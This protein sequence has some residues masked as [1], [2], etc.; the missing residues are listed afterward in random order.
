M[1]MGFLFNFSMMYFLFSSLGSHL[2]HMD[3]PR[4]GVELE[5]QLPAYTTAKATYDLS[6]V[7]NL[8]HGSQQCRTFNPL[9][10][11]RD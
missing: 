9:S 3:V 8:Y 6:H 11:A 1:H 10:G 2:Q 5:L 7:C 4:P